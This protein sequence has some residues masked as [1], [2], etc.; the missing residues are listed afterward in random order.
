MEQSLKQTSSTHTVNQ[1][2]E[3]NNP[4]NRTPYHK[5]ETKSFYSISIIF[6]IFAPL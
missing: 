1:L 3:T 4:Y 6:T 5:L 2:F